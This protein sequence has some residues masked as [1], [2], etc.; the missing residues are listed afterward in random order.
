MATCEHIARETERQRERETERRRGGCSCG[1]RQLLH[2]G[3][4][5]TLAGEINPGRSREGSGLLGWG[6]GNRRLAVMVG[7]GGDADRRQA[8]VDSSKGGCRRPNSG[9]KTGGYPSKETKEERWPKRVFG[10]NCFAL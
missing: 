7:L 2:G 3:I 9:G 5:D 8:G 1:C 4:I 6:R 10:E